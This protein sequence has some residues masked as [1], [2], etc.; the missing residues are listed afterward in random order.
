M[1]S[2]FNTNTTESGYRLKTLEIFNWGTFHEGDK[3][4]DISRISP[5]GQNTLLTGA[6]GSGKTTLVD[7]LLVLL[8]NPAKRFF[9]QSS[10]EKDKKA[11]NE[12][13]YVEGH[14][15]RTQNEE[16]QKAKVEKL[17]QDRSQTYSI[18]LGVFTNAQS[19][20]ITLIQVRYF[21]ASGLQH[22]YIVAKMELNIEKDIQYS[23]DGAWLK[24]LK[25]QYN[26][27]IE[28]F[29]GF[30]KYAVAF[31]R[32]FGMRS[33]KAMSLFNQ[34]VGMKIL[35]DLDEFIRINMLEDT[36]PEVQFTKLMDSYQTLLESY[37]ALEKAKTQLEL[38]QPIYESNDAYRDLEIQIKR[39][40]NQK[41]LLEP[42]F[43]SQQSIIW[44]NEIEQQDRKLDGLLNRLG[45]QESELQNKREQRNNIE[46]SIANNQ[47][48]QQIKDLEKDIKEL[49]KSKNQKEKDFENYNK[50][51]RKLEFLENPEENS[52]QDNY[53]KALDLQTSLK[54]QKKELENQQYE[55]R[56]KTDFKKDEFKIITQEINQLQNSS[57]KIIGRVTEIK[58]EIMEA[59]G[60]SESEI[61]FVAEVIQVRA[62]EKEIWNNAVEK[63][64][65]S[66][67]L[68][69]LI[70]EKYYAKVNQYVHNQRDIK[71]RI[72]YHKVETKVNKPIFQP[73]NARTVISKLEL[74]PNNP[75]ADWV[76]NHISNAFNFLCTEDLV[77]FERSDKA[78]LPSGLTRNKNR[79]ERDDRQGNRPIL[80]WDNRELLR[81]RKR[82]GKEMSDE[83]SK[84]ERSI[85]NIESQITTIDNTDKLLSFFLEIKYY[86]KL[87]WQT[88]VIE[89]EKL[90]DRKRELENSN[91]VYKD[92]KKQSDAL[93]EEINKL[94]K[95]KSNTDREIYGTESNI[96][97][98]KTEQK[99]TE[100]F[101]K[102]YD[103]D[104]LPTE[105]ESLKILT[106][107]IESQLN[108]EYFFKQKREFEK[109]IENKIST[110]NTH[111]I[112]AEVT[113]RRKMNKYR[114][115]S[116]EITEQFLDWE[117]DMADLG[118]EME[119]LYGYIDHYKR[120]K[121]DN[122]VVFKERFQQE[123]NKGVTKALTD[124]VN[125]LEIQHEKIED[126]I[127]EINDSLKEI[128]YS[129]NPDT[130][131]QIE[132]TKTKTKKINE[133][134]FEKLNSWQ[135]DYSKAAMSQN[136]QELEIENFIHK[137][138]PFIKELKDDEK[139]RLEITDVRNW[140]D[141]KAKEFWK[142]DNTQKQVFESSASL[143]GGEAAQLAYT[144][145]GAA[146]AH[147]FN[148]NKE[149]TNNRSFRFIVIDEAFSKLDEDKSKYLLQLCKNLGLQLMIVTPLTSIHL[150]E[151]DISVIHWVAKSKKDT[152]KSVVRDIPILEYKKE[153]ENL[154]AEAKEEEEMA[155]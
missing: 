76:E 98:L 99:E 80:G 20:P 147:Q 6:N 118:T 114:N 27:R 69:L 150:A 74:K 146:I 110:V 59:V 130:Y 60:A 84:L 47:I 41:R 33:E 127:M 86:S 136:M 123:F 26:D 139:R 88:D 14:Y 9:N 12:I 140:S 11:R 120:I 83:I 137:I 106:Q 89:I 61:P 119:D 2:L 23:S 25:R 149:N 108:Y 122:L 63:I 96:L 68:C 138:Q 133:F 115:P 39:L 21:T 55:T 73:F 117:T 52:F 79:H 32:Y 142:A 16:Q 19:V 81:E 53:Q 54:I 56:K 8:V 129:L 44:T 104:N 141:F 116:K 71:G 62:S 38:L 112:T 78:L 15:G 103:S 65:H 43:A 4:V 46:I 90:S 31:Q 24:K 102:N 95:D 135:M 87:N 126:K 128:P 100:I 97:I 37:R 91:D 66:F 77:E 57:S 155:I 42:Y 22:K 109:E 94:D 124:F 40:S 10:G 45:K 144:V 121:D 18:I 101:L 107:P 30:P 34:T 154:L 50:L 125:W 28:D 70:P 75:F 134:R 72:V 132:Q 82:V 36:E 151:N 1:L 85:R 13:T 29:D 3:K 51:A 67:G 148:I 48:V 152:R 5:H 17:R 111:K 49:E 64:L 145:L 113:I 93:Q 58:Q 35:G 7:A 92:L 153:K 105:L 143:S 131:I